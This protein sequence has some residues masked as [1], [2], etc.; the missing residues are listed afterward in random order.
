MSRMTRLRMKQEPIDEQGPS[1][2][3]MPAMPA[4]NGTASRAVSISSMSAQVAD[5]HQT[6]LPSTTHNTPTHAP[7]QLQ[8]SGD[9]TIPDQDTDMANTERSQTLHVEEGD[10]ML[11]LAQHSHQLIHAIQNLDALGID[12][13]LP[14]LPRFIVVGDQ[15][16]GKSS[17]V[18]AICDI[19]VPR[20][21]GTC[22]RCPFQITT[23]A[24]RGSGPASGGWSCSIG[25]QYRYIYNPDARYG[26][27]R[28]ELDRWTEQELYVEPFITI[29]DKGQLEDMLRRAQHA[30]V[31]P[32]RNPRDFRSGP[33]SETIEVGFSPNIVSLQIQG[34]GLSELSFFDLPGA[35]NVEPNGEDH[36]VV[37]VEKLLRSYLRQPNTLIL[38]TCAADQDIENSTAFR[39][40]KQ[41]KALDRCLGVLTK[42]DLVG[43]QRRHLIE[44]MLAGNKFVLGSTSA[45]FVTK[46]L[47]QEDLSQGYDRSQARAFEAEFFRKG[48]WATDLGKYAARFGTPNLQSAVSQKLTQQILHDLPQILQRVEHRLSDVDAELQSFPEKPRSAALTVLQ[49]CDALTRSIEANLRADGTDFRTLYRRLIKTAQSQLQELRPLVNLNT[50]GFQ[51]QAI[52]LDSEE[53]SDPTPDNTP[54]GKRRRVD[55]G[56]V[57]PVPSTPARGTPF[58]PRPTPTPLSAPRPNFKT[59]LPSTSRLKV[60][61]DEVR[62]LYDNGSNSGL[63]DQ[64]NP[65]VTDDLVRMSLKP[66]SELVPRLMG[67]ISNLVSEMLKDSID[68]ALATRK[69]TQLFVRSTKA[70]EHLFE[71]LMTGVHERVSNTLACE[72]NRPIT[73]QSV[74]TLAE[75]VRAKLLQDRAT[76]RVNEYYD[77][78]ESKGAKVPPT[79]ERMKKRVDLENG[80]L[81]TDEWGREVAAM[82]TP[83]TYYDI[84]SGRLLDS[85]SLMLDYNLLRGLQVELLDTLRFELRV[86]DEAYCAE[87]IA[88]DPAR[89]KRR[90]HLE[91][92]KGKL[93]LA[94]AELQGLRDQAG[95]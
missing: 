60:R 10:A 68:Q 6:P 72:M 49:A 32:S 22:T 92:E 16:T 25:L 9:T 39:Y 18:E 85:I 84:A 61:L 53:D 46:Q 29:E 44:G 11:G 20:D 19:T 38:L 52:S 27:N 58:R 4:A 21:Q 3:A 66:W 70:I 30:I 82:A 88:E 23:S 34:P 12:A 8:S 63:P 24:V 81:R 54:S 37:L 76:I 17:I 79:A 90:R 51:K 31:N 87:L 7:Q 59:D 43:P 77:T 28:N 57:Q 2:L 36:L 47:A 14:S 89:E 73:Y 95:F 64:L 91:V 83:L 35:I 50:P 15:S 93:N 80:P 67:Q 5:W 26:R 56:R 71:G 13:T 41:S 65:R 94:L 62:E 42:P 69:R 33:Y 75:P 45:W 86:T 1:A 74:K 40:A 55:D 78:L 48:I